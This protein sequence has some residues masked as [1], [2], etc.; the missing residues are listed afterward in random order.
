MRDVF[1]E[2]LLKIVWK[3]LCERRSA[4]MGFTF[5]WEPERGGGEEKFGCFEKG[6]R[7]PEHCTITALLM[8]LQDA[9]ICSSFPTRSCAGSLHSFCL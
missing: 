9:L 2:F 3:G 4:A 8:A 6:E 5:L 7:E 1:A